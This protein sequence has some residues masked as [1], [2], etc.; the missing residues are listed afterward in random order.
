M[1]N[2]PWGLFCLCQR[3]VN[4]RML[5][6]RYGRSQAAKEKI[7]RAEW[8]AM[9]VTRSPP[10]YEMLSRIAFRCP[11]FTDA[12]SNCGLRVS[13]SKSAEREADCG[14]QPHG[15]GSEQSW[16]RTGCDPA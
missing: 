10:I 3:A 14:R 16:S 11:E 15:S 9:A 1:A 13:Q 8:V 5:I 7:L 12:P 4:S 6:R 2:T